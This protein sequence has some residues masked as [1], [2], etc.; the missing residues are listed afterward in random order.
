[1]GKKIDI[2]IVSIFKFLLKLFAIWWLFLFILA[3]FRPNRI[4]LRT[5]RK[6]NIFEKIYNSAVIVTSLFLLPFYK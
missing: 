4:E 5:G 6:M 3:L 2:N 1:M